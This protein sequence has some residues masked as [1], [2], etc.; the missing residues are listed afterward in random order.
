MKRLSVWGIGPKMALATT[1][2]TIILAVLHFL[3]PHTFIIEGIPFHLFLIV[4][5]I[6]LAI[7]IPLYLVSVKT[8]NKAYK[9]DCLCTS[10]VY[11]I[12]RHPLYASMIFYNVPAVMLLF[13]SWLLLTVPVF[14]YIVFCIFIKKEEKYLEERFGDEFVFYKEKTDLVYISLKKILFKLAYS[15]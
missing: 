10:G 13:R 8:I 6:L 12:C 5:I 3:L 9:K 14:L 4:S 7:G 1:I 2:Y 11:G 15:V